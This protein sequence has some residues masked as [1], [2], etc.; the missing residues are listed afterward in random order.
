MIQ[1]LLKGFVDQQFINDIDYDKIEKLNVSYVSKQYKE[2]ESDLI[3][4]LDIKGE[5]AYLYVLLELQSSVDKYMALRTLSYILGF[6]DDLIKQEQVKEKL[7]PVFP[8]VL[9]TGVNKYTAP[10]HIQDII[11]HWKIT[12]FIPTFKYY[13]IAVNEG[14]EKQDELILADNVVAALFK[15]ISSKTNKEFR[16]A[17]RYLC[18]MVK[19]LEL[20]REIFNFIKH[21]LIKK[22]VK[23]DD[24]PF[25][26]GGL[27]MLETLIDKVKEEGYEEGIEEGR[28][29]GLEE[30]IQK[31]V[32]NV[33]RN[34]YKEGQSI[35]FISKITGLPIEK[36]K[37]IL[38]S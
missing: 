9:Y 7:P 34:A 14:K 19:S 13:K 30:G 2:T 17:I 16:E 18:R 5:E 20:R 4:K 36:L 26:E 25:E 23:I 6:Y 31:G 38:K 32:A 10:I 29:K 37:E 1:D 3:L 21:F 28:E 33:A 35:E 24:I 12:D 11:E 8:I 22:N 15:L 27:E